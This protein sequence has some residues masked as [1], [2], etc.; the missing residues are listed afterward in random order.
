MQPHIH[1]TKRGEA[2]RNPHYLPMSSFSL[3]L[4]AFHVPVPEGVMLLCGALLV[5]PSMSVQMA[6]PL[7]VEC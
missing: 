4:P 6:G 2:G 3:L 5:M 1:R 7:E